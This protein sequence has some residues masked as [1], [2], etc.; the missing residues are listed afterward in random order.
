MSPALEIALL[1]AQIRI[2][3]VLL[4]LLLHNT[5]VGLSGGIVHRLMAA[6]CHIR[7]GNQRDERDNKWQ[8]NE[9]PRDIGVAVFAQGAENPRPKDDP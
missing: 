2:R 5:V 3:A 6:G 1:D 7:D 4:L 8:Q 9:E